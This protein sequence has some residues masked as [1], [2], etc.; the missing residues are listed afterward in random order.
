MATTPNSAT[1]DA[2]PTDLLATPEE[3][4]AA[5]NKMDKLAD[6][7]QGENKKVASACAGGMGGFQLAVSAAQALGQIQACNDMNVREIR[8]MAQR[9][10]G[11]ADQY[12]RRG[13][14]YVRTLTS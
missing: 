9:L 8:E 12:E 3:L 10:R 4:R 11:T 5:A 14:T 2:Q 13:E 7:L 6:E 1:P